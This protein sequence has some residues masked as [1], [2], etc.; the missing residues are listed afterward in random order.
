[1]SYLGTKHFQVLTRS[2]SKILPATYRQFR[3]T[4]SNRLPKHS[5]AALRSPSKCFGV[6]Q[7]Q[8]VIAWP[9]ESVAGGVAQIP[10]CWF[11]EN[12]QIQ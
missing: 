9:V 1:M 7:Q 6:A 2:H 5:Q 8:G 3:V 11:T 10:V 4:F 12:A